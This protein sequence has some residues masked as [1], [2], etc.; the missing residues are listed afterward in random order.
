MKK[1]IAVVLSAAMLTACATAPDKIQASYVSP[2][3]YYGYDCEQIRGGEQRKQFHE[4]LLGPS[5]R[6]QPVMNNGYFHTDPF[7]TGRG[8]RQCYRSGTMR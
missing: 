6:V 5:P 1:I 7:T 4:D 8:P 2:I 3:Q